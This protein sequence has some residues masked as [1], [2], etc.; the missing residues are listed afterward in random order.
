MVP[1]KLTELAAQ[2]LIP[3]EGVCGAGAERSYNAIMDVEE[4][5]RGLITQ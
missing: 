1:I 4:N 2:W 3:V 5:Y